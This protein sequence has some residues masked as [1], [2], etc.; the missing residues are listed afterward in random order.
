MAPQSELDVSVVSPVYSC[1]DCLGSLV[2]GI[3]QALDSR[4]LAYEV[5]LVDDG[6]PDG[7]WER[8]AELAAQHREVRGV[9]LSRNF[10]QHPAIDAGLKHTRGEWV[11]V[12][13]CDLQDSPATIPELYDKAVGGGY[14]AVFAQRRDRQDKASKRLSSWAFY[15]VLSWLTGVSQDSSTANFGIFH[16]S[17]IDVVTSMP[18]RDKAFPL[19]VRWVG[20]RIGYQPVAHAARA[21]GKT[22]YSLSKLVR[23]ATHI[24]L[25]YSDKPLKLV[26]GGGIACAFVSFL[27]VALSVILFVNGQIQVAGYTS[28]IAATW[29]LG[30]LILFSVGV[31]GLYVGQVFAN[32]QGRP[33][34]VVAEVFDG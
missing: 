27:M 29:L 24:V 6:S 23:L 10:G 19:M 32:V 22:S 11:V 16:R 33:S 34:V 1:R 12:M 26:A 9:R 15:F 13:D 20:G 17:L 2:E 8:I 28:L 14:D 21:H 31:V 18:E 25:G 30:G 7:A 3:A 5:I 4:G